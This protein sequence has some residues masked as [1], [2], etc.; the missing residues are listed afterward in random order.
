MKNYDGAVLGIDFGTSNSAIATINKGQI[1]R[2]QIESGLDTL[3]T[4]IFFN[5]EDALVQ[6]GSEATKNQL[7]G[8]EG[9]Y[10]RALKS[11][12]GTSLMREKRLILGERLDFY[13]IISRFLALLKHAAEK[14]QNRQF[15]H[16]LSGRPVFFHSNDA[17]KNEQALADL[18]Q[19]YQMAGFSHVDFMFEPEA[20]A[21]ANAG[22][23]EAQGNDDSLNLIVDI[24]GGTSDYCLY[25][26]SNGTNDKNSQIEILASHGVRRGGTDFDKLLN[27]HFFMPTL[28]LGSQIQKFMSDGVIT[29]PSAIYYDLATWQKIAFVYSSKILKTV[30][31]LQR[32][33][34]KPALFG[35]L[36]NLL[37]QRLGHDLAFLAEATKINVNQ[38][39]G[40][41][42]QV[43]LSLIEQGLEIG[44]DQA[45]MND[46]MHDLCCDIK[47]NCCETLKLGD[48]KPE[49][50]SQVIFVG[51]SSQLFQV[52]TTMR[53]LFPQANFKAENVFTAVVDGL[54]LAGNQG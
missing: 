25:K 33:A 34:L 54:A 10:M 2:I 14:S 20:A 32:Q 8:V 44:I 19:C 53:S 45:S 47:R 17:V 42:A 43:D 18:R 31:E 52:Q 1:N 38:N 28:G 48:V 41:G 49:Q 11:V 16:V 9:R 4:A 39:N 3:P 36:H 22:G 29:A 37:D 26:K 12:L 7:D 15:S 6:F 23:Q 50:V 30:C 35:R 5:F 24:G 46:V 40:F 13:D 51:G 27:L 21:W